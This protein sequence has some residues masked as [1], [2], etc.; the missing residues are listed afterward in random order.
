MGILHQGGDDTET[1]SFFEKV[2]IFVPSMNK[3]PEIYHK[4]T[5]V[6]H[7]S[8]PATSLIAKKANKHHEMVITRVINT[9]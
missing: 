9:L 3:M 1:R 6:I 2:S 8:H 7:L 5:A 4:T